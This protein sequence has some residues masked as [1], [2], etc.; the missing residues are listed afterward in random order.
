M[1]LFENIQNRIKSFK[2]ASRGIVQLFKKQQN[3][4]LHLFAVIIIVVF[5]LIVKIN[6]TEWAIILLCIGMVIT[7]ETFNTAIE[8]LSDEITEEY[9][10]RI[11]LIKDLSAGAVLISAIISLIIGVLIFGPKVYSF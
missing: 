4:R 2:Y 7:A 3:A 5:G 9:N 8:N 1:H 6:I 10:E 11:K